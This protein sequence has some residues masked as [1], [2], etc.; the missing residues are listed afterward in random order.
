LE[1]EREEE[2]SFGNFVNNVRWI[3]CALKFSFLQ[4]K[5]SVY[6]LVCYVLQTLTIA[7]SFYSFISMLNPGVIHILRVL[8]LVEVKVS[9]C[10]QRSPCGDQTMD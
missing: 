8:S 5:Y 6:R 7:L 10:K 2:A 1:K 9:V 3:Y 4:N